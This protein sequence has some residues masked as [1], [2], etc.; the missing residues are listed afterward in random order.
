MPKLVVQL[1]GGLGNQMFQYAAARSLALENNLALVIDN[2]SGFFRDFQY[3]RKYELDVFPIEARTAKFYEFLPFLYVGFI[4]KFKRK[5]TLINR[6]PFGNYIQEP[7][8]LNEH[9][10][11]YQLGLKKINF[12][13]NTW[14]KGYW[15]TYKY[16]EKFKH[17]IHNEFILPTPTQKNFKLL[18]KKM[19][20]SESCALSIRLYEESTNPAFHALKKKTKNIFH[21]NKIVNRVKKKNPNFRFFVFCTHRSDFLKKINLPDDTVFVTHDDGFEGT[22]NRMWLLSQC[23]HHIFNNSAFYW[24]G[25]WLSS[26]NHKSQKQI[27]Y[28]ADNF[29]NRDGLASNWKR[30]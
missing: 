2:W 12:K 17:I 29:V 11:S 15:Q 4:A 23:K 21:I 8:N 13:K 22:L 25:A 26:K 28:A 18:G 20:N 19:L 27:I 9:S 7:L 30:F 16:F 6:L 24:W 14:I 10:T 5:L 3:K 1:S